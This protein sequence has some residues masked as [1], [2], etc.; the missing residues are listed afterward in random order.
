M[1]GR[2]EIGDS[3]NPSGVSGSRNRSVHMSG[4]FMADQPLARTNDSDLKPNLAMFHELSEFD[5]AKRSW[6]RRL[7]GHN[8][9]RRKNFSDENANY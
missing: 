4:Q 5:E 1:G 2:P 6:Q 9:R 7:A 3:A 8:E